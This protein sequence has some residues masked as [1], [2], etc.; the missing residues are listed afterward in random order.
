MKSQTVYFIM[1]QTLC[2]DTQANVI[3]DGYLYNNYES[4]STACAQENHQTHDPAQTRFTNQLNP[5]EHR[6]DLGEPCQKQPR[7]P[8]VSSPTTST[9]QN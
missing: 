5:S 3:W 9:R 1:P 6:C 2:G 7:A 8:R 4:K